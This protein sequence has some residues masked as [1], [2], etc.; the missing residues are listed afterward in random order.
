MAQQEKWFAIRSNNLKS[1]PYCRKRELNSGKLPS[2][3]HT[4]TVACVHTH[5]RAHTHTQ[6]NSK[7]LRD[8][9]EHLLQSP[10]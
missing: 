7:L 6:I 8:N 4:F 9:K 3:L 5:I 2:D 1:N 10:P